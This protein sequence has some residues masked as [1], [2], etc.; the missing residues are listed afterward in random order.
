MSKSKL[1]PADVVLREIEEMGQRSFIPSIGPVKGK[2]LARTVKQAKPK[3]ILEVGALYGY[4]SILMAKNAPDAKVIT[5]EK[6]KQN[7]EITV[8][9]LKRAGMTRRIRVIHGDALEVLP[10]L[11]GR[12]DLVFLDAEKS[13]YL[14]YLKAVE[15]RLHKGSIVVADN[16]GIFKEEML[17]YLD[18][19]RN[20]GPYK[21]RTIE[22]L[23][24]FSNTTKD[25]I[26]ISERL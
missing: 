26:E 4:S 20:R 5:V 14:Q 3:R 23:L 24:E 12:F 7:A 19:V 17:D 9:N 15:N 18:Y 21:S 1:D 16:V 13:Q 2:I 10:K 25:D 11:S 6:S 8:K 22:T